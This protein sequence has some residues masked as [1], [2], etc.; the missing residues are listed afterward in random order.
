MV[1][2]SDIERMVQEVRKENALFG[3]KGRLD[4]FKPPPAI[5]G[6]EDKAKELVRFLAGGLDKGYAVPFISVYGRSSSGKSTIVRFVCESLKSRQVSYAFVNLRMARTVFGC[7]SMI[8]AQ[9][10]C[11][12]TR[13]GTV[14]RIA[15]AV[16]SL[17]RGSGRKLFVLVLDE[18]DSLFSDRRGR[19]SD[20]VYR[21]LEMQEGLRKKGHLMTIVAISNNAISAYPL[22][23][24]VM[25]RMGSAAEVAFGAYSKD[26]LLSVLRKR[27]GRAVGCDPGVLEYCARVCSDEHGDARRAIELLRAAGELAGLQG[28]GKILKA[29]VD[30]AE[31]QL[32]RDRVSAALAGASYHAKVACGALV[33]VTYLTGEEWHATSTLYGQYC[34]LLRKDARPLTY[35]RVSA[36]LGE[37]VDAGLA[38]SATTS[39]G[40]SGGYGTRYRLTMSPELVGSACSAGWWKDLVEKKRRHDEEV[41]KAR[42]QRFEIKMGQSL[43]DEYYSG[44]RVLAM[45]NAQ[46]EEQARWEEFVGM[47]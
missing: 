24:R 7:A 35:R 16:E 31:E 27:A 34:K 1:D 44:P 10:D 25:S 13:V 29:H 17:F 21:L 42:Q 14:D 36:I 41:Q 3:D 6:R 46:R 4:A 20:F 8:L 12:D 22:D 2:S 30:A 26:D 5:V 39:R 15:G 40:R 19:P 45:Q 38:A 43:K 37:L 47:A 11:G 28:H 9:L 32:Q 33:R 23:D 18:F